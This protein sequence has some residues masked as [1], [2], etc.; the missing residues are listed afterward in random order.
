MKIKN[1]IHKEEYTIE[2][3][4]DLKKYL[5]KLNQQYYKISVI[6]DENIYKI[7]KNIL[8]KK[9]LN[10]IKIKPGERS[11]SIENKIMIEKRLLK[12]KFNRKSAIVALGGG[13]VGD[14]VGFVASTF[15][16]GIDLIQIPTSLV[17]MVDS[18]IGGKTGINN[19]LGKN[20]IGTF[21]NPKKIIVNSSFLKT[22]PESELRQG[23][24]EIIKYGVIYDSKLFK[25]LERIN[26]NFTKNSQQIINKI[27][28]NCITIKVKVVEE[29]F[30]ETDKRSILNF[31]HTVGHG[32]EK[33]FS[34]KKSHGDCIGLGMAIEAS[35]ANKYFDLND[36]CL[37]KIYKILDRFALKSIRYS[38]SQ[39]K[40]IIKH[41]E[42]D[43]KN[44]TN[45][46]TFS[47][48][49][50]IGSIML[51]NRKHTIEVSKE[52]INTVLKEFL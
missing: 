24:A 45:E 25:L 10:T 51:N 38:F 31:G 50:K 12:L 22:L 8:N 43:K 11:K 36:E 44:K 2:F 42:L 16:R 32:L 35:I 21:Y 9:Y 20:L 27:I 15:L 37:N 18:S 29:D 19:D 46:I 14:L 7:Y 40:S 30:K 48:P 49:N 13:V 28:K 23:L 6:T 34:Y 33:L 17:A 3:D 47:L 41:M 39:I 5:S 1:H 4:K 26:T 52:K